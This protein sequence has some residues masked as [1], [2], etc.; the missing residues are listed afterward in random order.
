MSDSS[1]AFTF[2]FL[3]H[4]GAMIDVVEYLSESKGASSSESMRLVLMSLMLGMDQPS[5]PDGEVG[6]QEP[7]D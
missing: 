7:W 2:L 4:R 1:F 6:D 3:D 5:L